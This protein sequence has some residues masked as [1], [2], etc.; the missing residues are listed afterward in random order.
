MYA[1]RSFLLLGG[2]AADIVS[3]IKGG[4]EISNCHFTFEQGTD[5]KGKATTKVFGGTLHI[6]LSQLPPANI[7]EWTLKSKKYTDG[8]IVVLDAENIAMEKI[9]FKNATCIGM[10]VEY[11]QKGTAYTSTRLVIQAEKIVVGSG[12]DFNNEWVV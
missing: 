12:I 4:H 9:L 10:E 11:T 8:A 7:I 3:L 1:H 2:G 6:T 5:D